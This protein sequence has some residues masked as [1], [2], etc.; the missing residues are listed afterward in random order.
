MWPPLNPP[1]VPPLRPPPNPPAAPP[2]WPPAEF[3]APTPLTGATKS[4]VARTTTMSGLGDHRLESRRDALVCSWILKRVMTSQDRNRR[5]D[6][7]HAAGA[8]VG[9]A[10]NR[11]IGAD[12]LT[13]VN[14]SCPRA[15][16]CRDV[17]GAHDH[18]GQRQRSVQY[19]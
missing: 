19:P 1:W 16:R 5:A 17:G 7:R 14:R 10:G 2:P 15:G 3:A 12:I 9:A 11:E 8:T 18:G 6:H 13:G 4:S